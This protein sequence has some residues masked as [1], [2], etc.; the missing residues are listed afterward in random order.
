MSAAAF[1]IY[2]LFDFLFVYVQPYLPMKY[3]R[4]LGTYFWNANS[5]FYVI[6]AAAYGV[7]LFVFRKR[8]ADPMKRAIYLN[9]AFYNILISFFITKHFI[10]ERFAVYPFVFSLIAIPDIIVSYREQKECSR[11]S[12]LLYRCVLTFWL[13]F[14]LLYFIFAAVNGFHGVYPYVS[15]LERGY[16]KPNLP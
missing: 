5:F 10:L 16:S 8:I 14:G 11:K 2:I 12:V 7:F 13:L 6:P 15:L 9:S 4:Y 1:F 3:A